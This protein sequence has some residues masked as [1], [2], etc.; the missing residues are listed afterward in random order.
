M[1]EVQVGQ[2]KSTKAKEGKQGKKQ[3]IK[4]AA[5]AAFIISQGRVNTQA[6]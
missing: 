6:L 2:Y 5:N 3:T 4:K 1:R